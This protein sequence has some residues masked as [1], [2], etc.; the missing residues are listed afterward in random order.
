MSRPATTTWPRL[1]IERGDHRVERLST[2]TPQALRATSRT[3]DD[4]AEPLPGGDPVGEDRVALVQAEL[5]A[6][7]DRFGWPEP[8]DPQV[9]DALDR[10]WA[11]VLHET[12]GIVAAEAADPAVWAFIT[13][14]VVPDLAAWR[15]PEGSDERFLDMDD[16]VF[17]RLWWRYQ[18]LGREL[19]D[20][21]GAAPFTDS[22]LSILVR[23]RALV[24]NPAVARALARA[25]LEA[26]L[27]VSQR[28]SLIKSTQRRLARMMPW[29]CFDALSP[30]DLRAV[31]AEALTPGQEEGFRAVL[32]RAGTRLLGR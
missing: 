3:R 18:V 30:H 14:V 27:P 21:A 7:A 8:V 31:V 10:A 16:H 22:E 25:V 2:D 29:I 1:A 13:C 24:A 26:P 9:A 4:A 15:W 11:G 12:T 23:R 20:G 17:A 28:G 5:R 32:H 6:A 19:L